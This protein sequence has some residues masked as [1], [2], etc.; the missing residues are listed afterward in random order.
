MP[1]PSSSQRGVK[2]WRPVMRTGCALAGSFFLLPPGTDV[3]KWLP[4]G[5][6]KGDLYLGNPRRTDDRFQLDPSLSRIVGS[7][8]NHDPYPQRSWSQHPKVQCH[9]GQGQQQSTLS[10][11]TADEEH[12]CFALALLL[13]IC[14]ALNKTYINIYPNEKYIQC[15]Y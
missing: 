8:Q 10:A 2:C 5:W 4:T 7:V 14:H 1:K 13:S 9:T 6:M 11:D 3:G 15:G 12:H